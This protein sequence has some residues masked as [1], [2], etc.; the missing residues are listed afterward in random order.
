MRYRAFV[1]G[2]RRKCRRR[3]LR[4][5]ETTGPQGGGGRI[6]AGVK[7]SADDAR[8]YFLASIYPRQQLLDLEKPKRIIASGDFA[9]TAAER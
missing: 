2:K 9:R 7:I 8:G 1:I 4:R 5:T 6:K 3:G